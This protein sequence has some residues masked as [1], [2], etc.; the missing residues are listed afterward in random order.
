MKSKSLIGKML[1]ICCLMTA[2][3]AAAQQDSWKFDFGNGKAEKGYIQV[4]S[5]DVYGAGKSYGFDIGSKV[6]D[7]NR[8]GNKLLG[9]FCTAGQP[10]F[11]SVDL[12][13]GN[14]TVKVIM[15]DAKDATVTTV[16]AE[17]RRLA[18]ERA[19]TT[20]GKYATYTFN[21]NIRNTVIRD[22]E[23]VRLKS[24]EYGKLNWDDKLTLEFND[25]RP[26]IN[27]IEI[28]RNDKVVTVFLAGD[29]TVVDQDNEPWCGW[30]QMIP[31]FFD[32]HIVFANY[33]ESGE[34]LAS[35]EGERRLAKLMTKIKAGDYLFIEFGHNNQKNNNITAYRNNLVKFIETAR[36]VGAHPVLVTPM[37]RRTFDAERKVTNSLA[38][39]TDTVQAV[40]ARY[41]VP[42]IE[43]NARSK[44]LYEAL[45]AQG[46]DFSKNAFVHYAAN[47]FPGQTS[48]LADNTHFNPYGGYQLAKCVIEEMKRLNLEDFTSHIRPDYTAYDPA[49][50]DPFNDFK[51][52]PSPT[53]SLV[54]P[55]GD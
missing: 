15:G 45:E 24:R 51:I 35:F 33:A 18:V 4:T 42:V 36:G 11:F 22:N 48:A 50:P 12:P 10:F 38:G 34:T 41:N 20:A 52:P 6:Q 53:I 30:G 29:S 19:A 13:E 32:E 9:D 37:N 44:V 3:Q 23:T 31:R 26:C 28:T 46:T 27:A 25:A 14:Y 40:G 55:E 47:T 8:G 7:V 2:G 43:L 54:K 17:S 5:A 21:V 39:Y 1:A 16:R 49:Q